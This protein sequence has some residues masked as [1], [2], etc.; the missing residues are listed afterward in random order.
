MSDLSS[1]HPGTDIELYER[2]GDRIALF[3]A[4]GVLRHCN[5][6]YAAALGLPRAELVG[7]S[8]GQLAQ[9]APNLLMHKRVRPGSTGARGGSFID[10]DEHL[11]RWVVNRLITDDQGGTLVVSSD[12]DP[13]L[14][15]QHQAARTV[16]RDEHTGLPNLIALR[17]DLAQ[18]QAPYELLA[19]EIEQV[20]RIAEA[21]G[22]EAAALMVLGISD[23]LDTAMLGT[24]RLY[25]TRAT[26]FVVLRTQPR[27]N[28]SDVEDRLQ[29]ILEAVRRPILAFSHSFKPQAT[30]GAL[31][32]P[33][34]R[35]VEPGTALRQLELA[36]AAA[37]KAR[38]GRPVWFR[39]AMEASVRLN[40]ILATELK[41]GIDSGQLHPHFQPILCAR[42]LAV[43]GVEALIRWMHPKLGI[44]EADDVMRLARSRGLAAKIDLLALEASIQAIATWRREGVTLAVSV[45]ATCE[46]LSDPFLPEK[47]ASRCQAAGV[48]PSFLEVEAPETFLLAEEGSS[49]SRL[50]A[51]HEL[52]VRLSIDDFGS[53]AATTATLVGAP[54]DTVKID[55]Q[56]A[57]RMAE[58]PDHRARAFRTLARMAQTLGFS[59][60]AKGIES[61]EEEALA[62]TQKIQLV[63]GYHYSAPLPLCEVPAF[64][65]SRST[66]QTPISAFSI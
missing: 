34:D 57:R 25:R 17:Q 2:L 24:E 7:R 61:A 33:A 12:A 18:L 30:V 35:A 50:R 14:V 37:R 32:V 26:E 23:N 21:I 29:V 1:P 66:P 20:A 9:T 44:I 64:V 13:E 36:G 4:M 46:T 54:I 22:Q 47:I 53:G 8:L 58:A 42:T 56:A 15:R 19:V 43:M 65:R 48:E 40:E 11:A 6:S 52:G 28:P 63:Q 39:P 60:V 51:L 31:S 62:R 3:D 16:T 55:W 10:F 41:Q 38:D 5:T 49:H 59:V 45:N 27:A